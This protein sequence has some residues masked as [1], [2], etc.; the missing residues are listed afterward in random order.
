M[1]TPELLDFIE[2]ELKAGQQTDA[3][4]RLLRD[5]GGWSM[6]D[7]EEAL[8]SLEKRK[9]PVSVAEMRAHKESALSHSIS[10]IVSPTPTPVIPV[11]LPAP[12]V[13]EHKV[14]S[15]H[16]SPAPTANIQ[17]AHTPSS[18]V[19]TEI[20]IADSWK[21]DAP[22]P[23]PPTPPHPLP[24]Q[25]GE[26]LRMQ[27]LPASVTT[28]VPSQD[29]TPLVT[30]PPIPAQSNHAL[31]TPQV[32]LTE[33]VP[34]Q[35]GNSLRVRTTSLKK[36]LIGV[37][38]LLFVVLLGVGGYFLFK[39][40]GPKGEKVFAT[41]YASIPG[42]QSLR[43]SG[44]TTLNFS[45]AVTDSLKA[46]FP[47]GYTGSAK[48]ALKYEGRMDL[49]SGMDGVHQFG[50]TAD[51][52]SGESAIAVNSNVELRIIEDTYYIKVTNPPEIKDIDLSRL[53]AYWI[54]VS[55]ADIVKRFGG[56]AA[57]AQDEYGSFG[58]ASST[59]TVRGFI[60]Q[61]PPFD[62]LSR[63]GEEQVS[64]VTTVHYRFSG[65][66]DNLLSLLRF[67]VNEVTGSPWEM[68]AEEE[69]NVKALFKGVE[70]DIWIDSATYL[71][72]KIVFRQPLKGTVSGIAVDGTLDVEQ[73]YSEY[74]GP[75]TIGAPRPVITYVEF[76]D[77]VRRQA[78][79]ANATGDARRI[80]DAGDIVSLL[81]VYRANNDN[82]YPLTLDEL[83]TSGLTKA[84]PT[85]P[86][87]GQYVYVPY[88]A[89][90]KMGKNF[91]CTA[92][93]PTCTAFHLGV[94]LQ[95]VADP[96]LAND[97]DLVSETISGLDTKG[98]AKE[99]GKACYDLTPPPR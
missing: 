60:A 12:V 66:P 44:E 37:G 58:G 85:D 2:A 93:T 17:P 96:I 61:N 36:I 73:G 21:H 3:L 24:P 7:I 25:V 86:D 50:I 89:E 29:L 91:V 40:M 45:G 10:P 32:T 43:Y 20:S 46:G 6:A 14:A 30:P 56:G 72:R 57:G 88:I 35:L 97:S 51:L 87:G 18:H 26:M 16:T 98:C 53:N 80:F 4:F 5:G 48:V 52:R 42:I 69:T 76:A 19:P 63:I 71:P 62:V 81:E 15:T 27:G 90:G 92:T 75:V 70:G 9:N 99:A 79:R 65:N 41:M 59:Q 38:I 28:S 78:E 55:P 83:V 33:E 13:G 23:S 1:I 82:R 49:K 39:E 68:T 95:S 22:P 31:A 77:D 74:N 67:M 54:A 11:P 47:A 8:A 34:K 84:L 94:S 64:G